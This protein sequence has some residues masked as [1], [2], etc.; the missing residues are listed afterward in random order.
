MM[1]SVIHG[2]C[3]VES[4]QT[5]SGS[6]DLILTEIACINTGRSFIGIEKEPK[7]VELARKRVKKHKVQ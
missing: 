5:E 3:L 2:D 6:V 1:N 7:Y 4:E